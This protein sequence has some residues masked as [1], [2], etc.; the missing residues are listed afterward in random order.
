MLLAPIANAD[1]SHDDRDDGHGGGDV[2]AAPICEDYVGH[3]TT[4]RETRHDAAS[5]APTPS[6]YYLFATNSK[7]QTVR[8]SK[9][10]HA[11]CAKAMGRY[12][13]CVEAAAAQ[14]GC[15]FGMVE[16]GEQ[17][18]DVGVPRLQGGR[19]VRRWTAA[20]GRRANLVRCVWMAKMSQP[21]AGLEFP[22]FRDHALAAEA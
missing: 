6:K 9:T 19:Y 3:A 1:A 22:S 21:R 13:Q 15:S 10:T 2:R 18:V 14:V 8:R 16:R 11:P 5:G 4:T 17:Q 12:M 7:M 20:H